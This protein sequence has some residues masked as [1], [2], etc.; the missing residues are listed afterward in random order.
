[1]ILNHLPISA[2]CG[3][4]KSDMKIFVNVAMLEIGQLFT[5]GMRWGHPCTMDTF[6]VF[7]LFFFSAFSSSWEKLPVSETSHRAF[8]SV[9]GPSRE[10]VQ[11]A[12]TDMKS[13]L[14]QTQSSSQAQG[15]QLSSTVVFKPDKDKVY[16]SL[17]FGNPQID[18]S[19][20]GNPELR[21]N[22]KI[23]PKDETGTKD[24]KMQTF[25]SQG[26]CP[27]QTGVSQK[28]SIDPSG[29]LKT[30]TDRQDSKD[31][32]SSLLVCYYLCLTCFFSSFYF[33]K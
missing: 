3:L 6:L 4:L 22:P 10:V 5:Q 30:G 14:K 8:I 13:I 27:K 23:P 33:F 12:V 20:Q 21:K 31:K 32:E 1:M 29:P 18:H 9:I 7:L 19:Q 11:A 2:Y 26:A 25:V 15:K 28:S 24:K 17:G 16:P